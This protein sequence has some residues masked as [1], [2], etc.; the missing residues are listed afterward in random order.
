MLSPWLNMDWIGTLLSFGFVTF[1]LIALQWGGN[2]RPWSDPVVIVFLVL[3]GVLMVAF[4]AWEHRLGSR[5]LVPIDMMLRKNVFA[6]SFSALFGHL[7]FVI[8]TYYLPLLYQV[9]GH[10]ATRSGVD[11][12]PFMISGVVSSMVA[13]GVA[14]ETGWAWPFLVFAPLLAAVG[15]GLF[16]EVSQN[17]SSSHIAGLQILVGIGLGCVVQLPIVVAQAEYVNEEHLV[18]Q[19][20]SLAT[21]IQIIGSSAGLAIAGAVFAAS[22]E[23]R[24]DTL[25]SLSP[26]QIGAVR[27]SVEAIFSL[28]DPQKQEASGAYVAA[29]Q[30]VWLIGVPS[31]ALAAM[32]ALIITRKRIRKVEGH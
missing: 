32:V 22:L 23:S 17:T 19:V 11:I 1:M 4:V 26:S 15:F 5:A 2:E 7:C 16:F 14:S 31:A 13:G 20:T 18:P 9:R 25:P 27:S 6:S 29:I 12:I 30:R 8:F 28:P 24:L 3:S 21:F 10:S